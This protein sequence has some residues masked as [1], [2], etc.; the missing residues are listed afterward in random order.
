[1][2]R[3][4]DERGPRGHRSGASGTAATPG[5]T[6]YRHIPNSQLATHMRRPGARVPGARGRAGRAGGLSQIPSLP[7]RCCAARYGC[8]W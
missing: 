7:L 2:A 8:W 1:M 6:G 4:R 3:K 5:R